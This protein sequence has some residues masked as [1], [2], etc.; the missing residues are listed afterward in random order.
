MGLVIFTNNLYLCLCK[1]NMAEQAAEI[2]H[3]GSQNAAA[4]ENKHLR[5]ST[6]IVSQMLFILP[7]FMLHT[8]K[9]YEKERNK[10]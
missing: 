9:L 6:N 10:V 3:A 5:D 2:W 1:M 8:I 7:E 4:D